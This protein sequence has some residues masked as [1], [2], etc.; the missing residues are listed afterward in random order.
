MPHV[1]TIS[2]PRRL[3]RGSYNTTVKLFAIT[4]AAV[5]PWL[6]GLTWLIVRYGPSVLDGRDA[7]SQSS[8][9]RSFGAR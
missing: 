6:A 2:L 8:R 3:G 9:L 5:L 7:P 1:G 4:V